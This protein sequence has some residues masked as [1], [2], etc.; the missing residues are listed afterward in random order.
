MEA[1]YN[2][3][4]NKFSYLSADLQIILP[5]VANRPIET[6]SAIRMQSRF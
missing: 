5:W 2:I 3:A 6:I 1:F 4:L